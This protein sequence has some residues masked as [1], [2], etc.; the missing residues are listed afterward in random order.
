MMRKERDQALKKKA[1]G[2]KKQG[3]NSRRVGLRGKGERNAC[4]GILKEKTIPSSQRGGFFLEGEG[5]KG[6][7]RPCNRE[8]VLTGFHK[9]MHF[10]LKNI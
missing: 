9:S 10:P 1:P 4:F 5:R 8:K 7:I 2:S 6:S 3:K